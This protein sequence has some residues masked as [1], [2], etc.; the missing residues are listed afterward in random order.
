MGSAGCLPAVLGVT[1]AALRQAGLDDP[2]GLVQPM[3]DYTAAQ[4]GTSSASLNA[5]KDR[6]STAVLST[7]IGFMTNI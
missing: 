1:V 5:S 4:S 2:R 7:K 6:D 3:T